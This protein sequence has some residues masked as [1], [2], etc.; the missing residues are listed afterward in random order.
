[1]ANVEFAEWLEA[2]R[3]EKGWTQTF[4]AERAGL[5]NTQ[6]SRLMRYERHPGIDA[7]Q[8]IARALGIQTEVVM[9]YAGWLPPYTELPD[10]AKS[11]G[12]RLMA[13]PVEDR[14]RAIAALEATLVALE[15]SYRRPGK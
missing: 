11:W 14:E 6:M 2:K 10:S 15:S 7:I 8:G 1:M 13:I 3:K 9:R 12:K 4:F 5:S